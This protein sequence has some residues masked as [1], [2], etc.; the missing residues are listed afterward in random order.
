M[1]IYI[2]WLEPPDN[3]IDCPL[4]Q[5]GLWG[6]P[7]QEWMD[8]A[9]NQRPDDC[10]MIVVPTPHGNL[11]DEDEIYDEDFL[12]VSVKHLDREIF[13]PAEEGIEKMSTWEKNYED[14]S[15]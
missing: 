11:I 4:G 3:C 13:I 15:N 1:G 10:P 14:K 12:H 2:N 7:S 6:D 5:C 8:A 9:V